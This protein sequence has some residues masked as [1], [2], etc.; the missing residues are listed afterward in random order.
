M[1]AGTFDEYMKNFSQK[2]FDMIF[3][4]HTLEHIV[5]PCD[6]VKQCSKINSKYFFME[7]P[8]FHYKLKD[9]PY[10]MLTDEHVNMFTF[11]SL[12]NLMT[13]CGYELLN[14]EIPF[15]IGNVAPSGY[16]SL[17]TLWKKTVLTGTCKNGFNML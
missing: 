15:D 3:L 11:E 8:S 6:F 1:F 17:R 7:V 5:N 10:G 13:V 9:E 16:P 14:A 12:Q 4:S 2:C